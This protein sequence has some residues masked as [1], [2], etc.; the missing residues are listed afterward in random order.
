MKAEICTFFLSISLCLVLGA[1]FVENM[2]VTIPGK[3]PICPQQQVFK[4]ASA[5]TRNLY[6][7]AEDQHKAKVPVVFLHG[8][9]PMRSI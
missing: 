6:A 7:T 1:V 5:V 8:P 4:D 2:A 9:L 3:C